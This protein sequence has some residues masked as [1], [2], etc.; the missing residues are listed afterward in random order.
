M[1]CL[2]LLKDGL[3]YLQW[4]NNLSITFIIFKKPEIYIQA[5]KVV[6]QGSDTHKGI[7]T[8]ALLGVPTLECHSR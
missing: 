8:V 5:M 1:L 4:L 3:K 6:K 2:D 7:A